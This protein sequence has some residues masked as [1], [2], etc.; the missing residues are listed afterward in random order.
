MLIAVSTSLSIVAVLAL[1][2]L[3]AF[4]VW[5]RSSPLTLVQTFWWSLNYLIAKLLW[6]TKVEGTLPVKPNQ[7]AVIVANHRSS[8]DPSFIQTCI[9][10]VVYWMVAREYCEAPG[11]GWILRV[12]QVIPVGRGGVDTAA[13]KQAIRL[14]QQG[15]LVGMFPEGRINENKDTLLLPGRPGAALVALKA[16]VPIIPIFITGSPYDG[17]PVG[18]LKM[19]AKVRVKIGEPMD[20]SPYYGREKE[21]GVTQEIT[22]RLLLEMAKPAGHP[23][24]EP[25]LAG[26]RWKPGTEEPES[27]NENSNHLNSSPS[28]HPS[29]I[30]GTNG[31]SGAS[32]P[33]K[34]ISQ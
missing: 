29:E 4:I 7:G 8:V 16:R 31:S 15:G 20:L 26:R 21:E 19:R 1:L 22:K 6:R 17:T 14:A 33:P 11:I 18:P 10:R 2:I 13:T 12:F 23:E 30:S 34:S 25:Q 27:G 32:T 3:T 24:F 5:W 9:R 28:A